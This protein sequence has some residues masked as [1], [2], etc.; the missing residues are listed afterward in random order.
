M[1]IFQINLWFYGLL[2]HVIWQL[3][4]NILEDNVAFI[5]R[6]EVYGNRK[7]DIH[8]CWVGGGV[9]VRLVKV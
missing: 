9:G 6:V 8:V 3:D 7:V 2:H 5:F 1:V 4:T